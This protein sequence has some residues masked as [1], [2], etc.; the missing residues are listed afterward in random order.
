MVKPYNPVRLG[1]SSQGP[2]V[3]HPSRF[4]IASVLSDGQIAL[5]N[6]EIE[7]WEDSVLF[8]QFHQ[9]V[10]AIKWK[11][12]SNS[13]LA[14]ACCGGVCLWDTERSL[15]DLMGPSAVV[16][17]DKDEPGVHDLS[18]FTNEKGC[19]IF[20]PHPDHV[21]IHTM[22]F[23]PTGHR[24]AFGSR[25]SCTI[26]V[27]D[28]ALP[29]T[30]REAI[31]KRLV[32]ASG[33]AHIISWSQ[34]G[35]FLMVAGTVSR[36]LSIY[37]TETWESEVFIL[38]RPVRH[39][40]WGSNDVVCYVL[41]GSSD[42]DF[43]KVEHLPRHCQIFG[44]VCGSHPFSTTQGAPK[45][46]HILWDP[47]SQALVTVE[48]DQIAVWSTQEEVAPFGEMTVR[49]WS[50]CSTALDV[51]L[52]GSVSLPASAEE[53]GVLQSANDHPPA[54]TTIVSVSFSAHKLQKGTTTLLCVK[55]SDGSLFVH[56]LRF[57]PQPS[58]NS[59]AEALKNWD[60]G[61]L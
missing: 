42:V 59:G 8:H 18:F 51:Q 1:S 3:W 48:G 9:E 32:R 39:A 55:R 60:L 52:R 40:L 4:L 19:M 15:Q 20:V 34:S 29:P 37:N 27:Y 10:S 33:G 31:V 46:Q 56:P 6:H 28:T 16:P 14:V 21:T 30:H 49:Q 44:S 54:C 50:D 5:Y 53:G 38:R 17:G 43:L 61:A 12:L 22:D 7:K 36:S 26:L 13:V 2:A 11:P 25:D 35:R 57:I 58:Q 24:L 45:L 41:E 23:S 47:S